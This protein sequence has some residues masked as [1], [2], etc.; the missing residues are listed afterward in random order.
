MFSSMAEIYF[1]MKKP[2]VNLRNAVN[3]EFMIIMTP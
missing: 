1:H 2:L 3:S